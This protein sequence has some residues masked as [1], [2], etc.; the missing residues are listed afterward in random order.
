MTAYNLAFVEL[1]VGVFILSALFAY[2]WW[3][4]VRVILFRQDLF[5]ARDHLWD[6]ARRLNCLDDPAYRYARATINTMIRIASDITVVTIALV[7][8][9]GTPSPPPPVSDNADMQAE[10]DK[11]RDYAF[12]RLSQYVLKDRLSGWLVRISWR[13]RQTAADIK[14]WMQSSLPARMD[15]TRFGGMTPA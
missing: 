4:K 13:S 9:D 7:S 5:E 11:V 12:R 14:R 1:G 15:R 2:A 6:E 10:I 3:V 8:K